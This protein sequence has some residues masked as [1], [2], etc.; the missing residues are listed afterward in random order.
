[1][2]EMKNFFSNRIGLINPSL[3]DFENRKVKKILKYYERL[4]KN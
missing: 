4:L 2:E 1:M 3:N